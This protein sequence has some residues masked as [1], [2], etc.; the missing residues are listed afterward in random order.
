MRNSCCACSTRQPQQRRSRRERKEIS[1]LQ[2]W[3]TGHCQQTQRD[4]A[5]VVCDLVIILREVLSSVRIEASMQFS[6]CLKMHEDSFMCSHQDLRACV[7]PQ[8]SCWKGLLPRATLLSCC[9]FLTYGIQ[10]CIVCVCPA[11]ASTI[12]TVPGRLCCCAA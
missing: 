6:G 1:L 11:G 4:R 5:A 10:C 9:A 7:L 2:A 12:P 3:L 8:L